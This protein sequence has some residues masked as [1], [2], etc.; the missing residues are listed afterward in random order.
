M[1]KRMEALAAEVRERRLSVRT[2]LVLREGEIIA[3]RDFSEDVPHPMYSVSKTFAMMEI[4]ALAGEGRLSLGDRLDSLLPEARGTLWRDTTVEQL[5]T[6]TTG[7]G[8]CPLAAVNFKGDLMSLFVSAPR[9]YPAG[10]R[11]TY[12]NGA[13][14]AL[15]RIAGRITGRSLLEELTERVF[16]P[17]GIGRPRWEED[18]AGHTLGFTGL[19]LTAEQLSRAGRL[20]LQGGLWQGQRLLPAAFLREAMTKRTETAHVADDWATP[21]SRAGYGY[22]LWMNRVPGSCRMDGLLGQYCVLLPEERAAVVY[23]SDETRDMLGIL[24][25]TWKHLLPGLRREPA[26]KGVPGECRGV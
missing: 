23:V 15:S 22:C 8:A 24:S 7:H 19:Y 12:N 10:S 5:L 3:R 21:D 16:A 2:A 4:G 20:L 17:L 13:V 25:L 6:M 26:R 18:G 14:Y 1:E 9:V 11:F